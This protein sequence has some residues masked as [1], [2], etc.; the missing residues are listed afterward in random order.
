M[1]DLISRQEVLNKLNKLDQ[2]ELYLPLT[3]ILE[4][5]SNSR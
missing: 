3:A 5:S 2:Q 1:S 4:K